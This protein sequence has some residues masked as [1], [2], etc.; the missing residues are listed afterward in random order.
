MRVLI[1]GVAG[2]IGS[3]LADALLADGHEVYGIDN[4]ATGKPENVP[5]EI[6]QFVEGSIVAGYLPVQR[7]EA[8]F[9]CAASYKDP[10]DWSGD[11]ET[12]AAGTARLVE[13]AKT[14]QVDRFVY[15]QTS[16]CYGLPDSPGLPL[17]VDW[18]LAPHGSYG[19]SKTAGEACILESGLDAISF[20]LANLYGPRNFTGP[21]PTFYKRLAA[22]DECAVVDSRRD[23]VYVHDAIDLFARAAYGEGDPGVYHVSSG[24]DYSILETYDAVAAAMGHPAYGRE[25]EPREA[26]DAASILLDP[27]KTCEAFGWKASTPLEEGVAAAVEWYAENGVGETYTHLRAG[28]A[29]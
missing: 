2:F 26:D 3:H 14:I 17:P 16:C 25:P 19:W 21:I 23:F 5:A 18:P 10:T 12:N 28:S 22:G 7:V 29:R 1:T 9:H 13:Y 27:S 6:T 8:I 15:L 20:R 11:M 24:G 4:F